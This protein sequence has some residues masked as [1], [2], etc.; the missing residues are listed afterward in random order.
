MVRE[1]R[2]RNFLSTSKEISDIEV[3]DDIGEIASDDDSDSNEESD[4]HAMST[5]VGDA[6]VMGALQLE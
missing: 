6:R 3:I 4:T 1:F 5:R 2:G